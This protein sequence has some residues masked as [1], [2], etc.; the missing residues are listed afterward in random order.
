MQSAITVAVL[1]A[2]LA[3]KSLDETYEAAKAKGFRG[4]LIDLWFILQR[5]T[6]WPEVFWNGSAGLCATK[7]GSAQP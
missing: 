1:E 6:G 3:G 4:N 5:G 7:K 2:W